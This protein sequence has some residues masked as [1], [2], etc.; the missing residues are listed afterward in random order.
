[1]IYLYAV[2]CTG[3]NGVES[4]VVQWMGAN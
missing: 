1:V 4:E 3:T 2:T